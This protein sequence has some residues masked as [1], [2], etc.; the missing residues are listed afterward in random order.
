MKSLLIFSLC[1]VATLGFYRIPLTKIKTARRTIEDFKT[2][3]EK[4]KNRWGSG[5][6]LGSLMQDYPEDPLDNYLDAQYYGP[7]DIGTPA[8]TFNVIFDTGSSNFW[9]PSGKCPIWSWLALLTTDTIVK[10]PALINLMVQSSKFSM[11]LEACQDSCP[12]I[13][14]V[15]LVFV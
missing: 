5:N 13:Q 11:D 10:T 15:L 1:V 8:Q 3:V 12:L 9:V 7:V 6:V 4:I 14:P 2:S